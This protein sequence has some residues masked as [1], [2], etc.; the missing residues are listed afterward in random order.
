LRSV[1]AEDPCRQL[2]VCALHVTLRAKSLHLISDRDLMRLHVEALFT[3]DDHGDLVS[4]NDPGG[5][6]APRFF[7]GVTRDATVR[8]FRHDVSDDLRRE[9]DA[10]CE[11]SPLHQSDLASP[12][13]QARF[14]A[15]LAR[16]GPVER[17]WAGPAF[18]FPKEL[19]TL[20]NV[21]RVTEQNADLLSPL[22]EPWL[23]DAALCQPMVAL[24]VSGCAVA[25]CCSVRRTAAAHEAGVETAPSYRRR[26]YAAQVVTAWAATAR[27]IG[28]VPLY[29][30]SWQ[31][32]ASLAVAHRLSLLHFGSDLHIT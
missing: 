21:V 30:T 24:S 12:A 8:R 2:K 9:L 5:R 10:E 32:A 22:L 6:P 4:I 31:N 14:E 15:I 26:G 25:V 18:C 11:R 13:V 17:T 1:D 23:G 27:A 19:P 16:S 29:S 28:R 20:G 3:H 7:I